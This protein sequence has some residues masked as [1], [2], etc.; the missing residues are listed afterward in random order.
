MRRS[1]SFPARRTQGAADV[2]D[3]TGKM[4]KKYL[5]CLSSPPA[6]LAHKPSPPSR[7]ILASMHT[8]SLRGFEF[9]HNRIGAECT[10]HL[11]DQIRE[12]NHTGN[13]RECSRKLYWA[14]LRNPGPNTRQCHVL[15]RNSQGQLHNPPSPTTIP[16]QDFGAAKSPRLSAPTLCHRNGRLAP[17]QGVHL[18]ETS[19]TQRVHD[20]PIH[21]LRNLPQWCNLA[22]NG[23]SVPHPRS[24]TNIP[25]A[26]GSASQAHAQP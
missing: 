24:T 17:S 21:Q 26:V 4:P 18:E 6:G 16:G 3:R 22:R 15:Q 11:R 14:G 8:C 1:Q 10:H 25:P 12:H 2:L 19:Q 9:V 13:R 5:R 23:R 7:A 20:P